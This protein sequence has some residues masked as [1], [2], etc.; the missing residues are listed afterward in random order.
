MD[1][2]LVL[3]TFISRQMHHLLLIHHDL[4]QE[5]NPSRILR[6][7]WLAP[8]KITTDGTI[9]LFDVT[10]LQQGLQICVNTVLSVLTPLLPAIA[11]IPAIGIMKHHFSRKLL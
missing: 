8:I 1:D 3:H 7:L 10:Y 4:L 2:T 6:R 5:L 9:L 11:S